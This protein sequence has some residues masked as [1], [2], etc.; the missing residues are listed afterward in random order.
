MDNL[1]F[2]VALSNGKRL[3][4]ESLVARK[5]VEESIVKCETFLNKHNRMENLIGMILWIIWHS[6]LGNLKLIGG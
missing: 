5:K 4:K 2:A 1:D 3:G 6:G